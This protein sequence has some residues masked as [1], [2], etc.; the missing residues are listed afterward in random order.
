MLVPFTEK[1]VMKVP[2][3]AG[4]FSLFQE[5]DLVY[6]GRTAPRSNLRADLL[7]ALA[8]AMAD[9]MLASHFTYEL[10]PTPKTRAS[11]ELRSYYATWGRLPVYNQPHGLPL[12]E[13]A[14]LR[15]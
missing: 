11:E 15:R 4:I 6:I 9:D 13:R 7:H 2:Q 14:E 5:R 12:G 10:T 8:V 1:E 3:E